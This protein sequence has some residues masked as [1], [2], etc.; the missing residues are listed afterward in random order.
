M[1]AINT[2]VFNSKEEEIFWLVKE[3]EHLIS[4]G[5]KPSEIAVIAKKHKDL[6]YLTE[7]LTSKQI[8]YDYQKGR[9]IFNNELILTICLEIKLIS[10]LHKLDV[11]DLWIKVFSLE[12]WEI[13]FEEI[14][15]LNL[16]AR[17][18]GKSIL[19]FILEDLVDHK[20]YKIAKFYL[21]IAK[22]SQNYQGSVILDLLIGNLSIPDFYQR[23]RPDTSEFPNENLEDNSITIS[24]FKKYFF[25]EN[26]NLNPKEQQLINL[27]AI[28]TFYSELE[29]HFQN[30]NPTTEE[31]LNFI[32]F[33][34]KNNQELIDNFG[35]S[36]ST[37]SINLLTAHKAKGLEFE[38]VFVIFAN[39]ENW[40]KKKSSNITLP[41]SFQIN[42][43]QDNIEDFIRLF[44]VACTRAK[45]KLYITRH[46]LD[47]KNRSTKILPFLEENFTKIETTSDNKLEILKTDLMENK[48]LKIKK[49]DLFKLLKPRLESYKLTPSDL[50]SFIDFTTEGPKFFIE[51]K[52]IS[53]PEAKTSHQI[54]GNS[55]HRS[56][57]DFILEWKKTNQKPQLDSILDRF[58]FYILKDSFISKNECEL[59]LKE[60]L[61]CLKVFASSP[62]IEWD[63]NSLVEYDFKTQNILL[64]DTPI[65]GRADR[66]D[67]DET[68]NLITIIDYKTGKPP[69]ANNSKDKLKIFKYRL[70]L[71]FYKVL[72]ENSGNFFSKYKV[73][74]AKLEYTRLNSEQEIEVIDFD[75]NDDESRKLTKLIKVVYN[76][77]INLDF[78][79]VSAYKPN[80][81]GLEK[82][83]EDLILNNV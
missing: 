46:L 78:P 7:I 55:I 27:S 40:T 45:E 25:S 69:K 75:L 26:F 1:S 51:K 39:T 82:F 30:H 43:P 42:P 70:Q 9:N 49:V 12:F 48:L 56:L 15:S 16:K 66:L 50:L 68:K 23:N 6:K 4:A 61:K 77:I 13:P 47:E 37:D 22:I 34:L 58:K 59:Y 76:K 71:L 62:K 10:N 19:N 81:E 5:T 31:I 41:Y 53:F 20:F 35:F 74:R 2:Y 65:T 29:S 72:I 36:S 80:L 14:I 67:F 24:P 63:K 11:D 83:I 3:I 28:K 54:Y 38:V 64:D 8:P 17:K 73:N 79:D 60:G 21:E 32:N 52:L 44:Y 33:Y 57:R 18:S